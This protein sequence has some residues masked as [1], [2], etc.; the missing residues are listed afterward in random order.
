VRAD[1]LG[2]AIGIGFLGWGLRGESGFGCIFFLFQDQPSDEHL[3]EIGADRFSVPR[4]DLVVIQI[5][6]KFYHQVLD[7]AKQFA[8]L[9]V[10]GPFSDGRDP[11]DLL[12]QSG[13]SNL[14]LIIFVVLGRGDGPGRELMLHGFCFSVHGLVSTWSF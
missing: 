8:A 2:W 11:L 9:L 1:F 4:V 5:L 7:G 6:D 13:G 3:D 10:F 12:H 14:F